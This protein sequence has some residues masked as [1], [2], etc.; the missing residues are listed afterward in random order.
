MED[1]LTQKFSYASIR[2]FKNYCK[3]EDKSDLKSNRRGIMT[4]LFDGYDQFSF[5][6]PHSKRKTKHFYG[7]LEHEFLNFKCAYKNKNTGDRSFHTTNDRHI[8]RH[9]ANPFA[10]IILNTIERSV[11]RHGEK[12]TIKVYKQVKTREINMK[13]FKKYFTVISITINLRTGNFTILNLS[14]STKTK[15]IRF[16][17]NSF[18][19]LSQ[20]CGIQNGIFQR[21][22]HLSNTSNVFSLF[23]KEFNDSKFSF[24]IGKELGFGYSNY[25]EKPGLF[26]NN[27]MK[28]FVKNKNIKAPNDYQNLLCY[29]YPT[30]KFLKKNDRKLISSVLDFFG[31]RS[32]ITVKLLHKIPNIN[33]V[34][35]AKI[36]YLLGDD[37][38]KY[39]GNIKEEGFKVFDRELGL[40]DIN[41]IVLFK[42]SYNSIKKHGY[43]INEREKENIVRII[44]SQNKKIISGDNSFIDTA[45]DHF[46]MMKKISEIGN[47]IRL[48]VKNIG[49]FNIE[50]VELSKT[51]SAI[52]KGWV[53]EYQFHKDTIN[54]LEKPLDVKINLSDSETE[55]NWV[56]ETFYPVVLKREEEYVEEGKTMHHCVETYAD[57]DNSIIISIRTKDMSDRITCEFSTQTGICIQSRHF[58]NG[59]PPGDMVLALDQLK[60]KT[61]KYA[62]LGLL[63]NI[64]KK[65]VPIKI[66]GVEVKKEVIAVFP[67]HL[68]TE[69]QNNF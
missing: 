17:T 55:P 68:F 33:I 67:E 62:K 57:R 24:I 13:Y 39:L 6:K 12:L 2:L 16:R 43:D 11:R 15:S 53:I 46:S 38:G 34:S 30:E 47:D 22:H 7:E 36:C 3:I 63:N 27:M 54:D 9:F 50:H 25:T 65:R 29:F 41:E 26:F 60:L 8:K 69:L 37:Y 18:F 59:T 28:F 40:N 19:E 10:T 23:D 64:E 45:Y 49:D 31:I 44:N 52:E 66:N 42:C 58:C 4:Q 35:L 32:K 5:G 56:T 20:V 48:N 21:D 61:K 51:I 14:N 1:L